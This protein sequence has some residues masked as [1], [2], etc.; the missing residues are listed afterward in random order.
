MLTALSLF[1]ILVFFLWRSR[2]ISDYS[3][4]WC[5]NLCVMQN[6]K[7]ERIEKNKKQQ[8]QKTKK[9][10]T[11]EI[12]ISVSSKYIRYTAR[13]LCAHL[14]GFSVCMYAVVEF[15]HISSKKKF[16]VVVYLCMRE[17]TSF[18]TYFVHFLPFSK[19]RFSISHKIVRKKTPI[20]RN[21]FTH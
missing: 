2:C 12:I 6:R 17:Q 19:T 9:Q 3:N 7:K 13:S 20:F 4:R 5:G 8:T 15:S 14:H 18:C 10:K 11:R 21:V 1:L 16:K